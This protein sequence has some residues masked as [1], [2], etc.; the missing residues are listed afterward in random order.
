MCCGNFPPFL[1]YFLYVFSRVACFLPPPPILSLRR[2]PFTLGGPQTPSAE[3]GAFRVPW[4]MLMGDSFRSFYRVGLWSAGW[5]ALHTLDIQRTC[6]SP[7]PPLDTHTKT[8]V[9]KLQE[10]EGRKEEPRRVHRH[11]RKE[12]ECDSE[13]TKERA[14]GEYVKKAGT[15]KERERARERRF[16]GEGGGQSLRRMCLCCW[17]LGR[18]NWKRKSGEGTSSVARSSHTLNG[19]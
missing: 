9:K 11:E 10:H 17:E 19:G 8:P 14:E 1:K 3:W 18:K 15:E 12:W 5:L 13:K 4:W 6:K 7:P 16:R 2:L